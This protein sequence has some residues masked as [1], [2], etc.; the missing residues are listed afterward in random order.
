MKKVY[1]GLMLLIFFIS[2]CTETDGVSIEENIPT[3]QTS[4]SEI[5]K[6]ELEE[7]G[8]TYGQSIDFDNFCQA[9]SENISNLQEFDNEV[10]FYYDSL[11]ELSSGDILIS[12]SSIESAYLDNGGEQQDKMVSVLQENTFSFYNIAKNMYEYQRGFT[13]TE[14]AGN[15]IMILPFVEEIGVNYNLS[16][17]SVKQLKIYFLNNINSK[18]NFTPAIDEVMKEYE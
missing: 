10:Q 5:A 17:N 6:N 11:D 3:E 7:L 15:L 9:Y 18:G 8:L 14:A 16:E 12:V 4:E 13:E 2:G 1:L